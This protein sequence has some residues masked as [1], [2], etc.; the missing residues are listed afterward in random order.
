MKSEEEIMK[1]E[2]KALNKTI[3]QYSVRGVYKPMKLNFVLDKLFVLPP[4]N[5]VLKNNTLL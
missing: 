1:D 3:K 4:I 2:P 5:K